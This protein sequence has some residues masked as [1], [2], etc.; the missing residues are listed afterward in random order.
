MRVK[1]SPLFLAKVKKVDVRIYKSLRKNLAIFIK[2]PSNPQLDNHELY[3]E[4]EGFRSIDVTANWRA[5]YEEIDEGEEV[6][7]YFEVLGTHEEL[8]GN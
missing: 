6:V 3:E 8:Y 4:W 5:I 1:Y 7:A 2:D